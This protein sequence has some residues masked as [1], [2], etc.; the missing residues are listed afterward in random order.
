M[1]IRRKNE[2][3]TEQLREQ[4]H[5]EIYRDRR[6]THAELRS[7]YGKNV[8]TPQEFCKEFAIVGFAPPLAIV[9]RISDLEQGTVYY[10]GQPPQ[11]YFDEFLGR[12]GKPK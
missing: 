9:R 5:A 10:Q 7:I 6:L 8:W 12:D 2:E 11:F 3:F 4:I 1:I